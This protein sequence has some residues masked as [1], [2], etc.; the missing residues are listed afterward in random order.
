MG[1]HP[2]LSIF[3]PCYN[4]ASTLGRTLSS[5]EKLQGDDFELVFINDG[6]TD[7]TEKLVQQW[8]ADHDYQAKY[9]KQANQGKHAAHN[10]A[11][12]LSDG[13]LFLTLDAGDEIRPDCLE[14]ILAHWDSVPQ[15]IKDKCAGIC[16]LCVD[17]QGN[18]S[19]NRFDVDVRDASF[20]DVFK[21]GVIRGEKRFA[22]KTEILRLYPFPRFEGERHMRPSY[23]L[24]QLSHKYDLLFTNTVL[25][26]N[27]READGI[28]A[29]IFRYRMK[30]PQAF[31]CYFMQEINKHYIH[32]SFSKIFKDYKT[33]IRYSF[34]CHMGLVQQAKEARNIVV[35]FLALPQGMLGWIRDKIRLR[36]KN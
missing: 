23:I 31:R 17:E 3:I 24:K 33:Y 26:V 36:N 12:E 19:G 16:G 5:I 11:V 10:R 25:E 30:N 32:Y 28:T 13:Y 20:F 7:E 4:R 22:L 15:E 18:I 8:I 21:N 9:E 27:V 35:W 1:G 34:H 29:N 14:N 2:A 6:S